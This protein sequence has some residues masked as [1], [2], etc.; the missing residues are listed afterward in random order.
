MA[1]LATLLAGRSPMSTEA[2]AG[3][4]GRTAGLLMH[5][6]PRTP[7]HSEPSLPYGGAGAGGAGDA[8]FA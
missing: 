3:G 2:H 8:R 5:S 1:D 6:R 4:G 7:V